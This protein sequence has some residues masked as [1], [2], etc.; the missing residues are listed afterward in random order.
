MERAAAEKEKA[1]LREKER[2]L[3]AS[4]RAAAEARAAVRPRSVVRK[5][6]VIPNT[7]REKGTFAGAPGAKASPAKSRPTVTVGKE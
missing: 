2:K 7:T 6:P 4:R 1:C 3:A 5:M